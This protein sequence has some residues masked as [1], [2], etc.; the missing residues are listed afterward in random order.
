MTISTGLDGIRWRT[1][2]LLDQGKQSRRLVSFVI[3]DCNFTKFCIVIEIL[4]CR[5]TLRRQPCAECEIY[6][7]LQ[8]VLTRALFFQRQ[9]IEPKDQLALH[10]DSN[11]P[12]WPTYESY[13]TII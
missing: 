1:R 7:K 10:P 11:E 13:A 8:L 12:G 5:R 4:D 6:R 3:K 9:L 2:Q